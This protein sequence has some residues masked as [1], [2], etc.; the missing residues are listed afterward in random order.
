MIKEG[1]ILIFKNYGKDFS[2]QEGDICKCVGIIQKS[3]AGRCLP[4]GQMKLH[5]F[6]IF[7]IQYQNGVLN[8][9]IDKLII[10]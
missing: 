2:W 4:T 5:I 10:Y 3:F 6:I 7:F 1:D 8:V 9:D